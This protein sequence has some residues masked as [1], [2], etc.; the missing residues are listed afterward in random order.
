MAYGNTATITYVKC[1][2]G[3]CNCNTGNKKSIL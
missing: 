1:D 3:N 2:T